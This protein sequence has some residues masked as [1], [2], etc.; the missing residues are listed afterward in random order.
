MSLNKFSKFVQQDIRDSQDPEEITSAVADN[1]LD[2]AL[3]GNVNEDVLIIKEQEGSVVS[4]GLLPLRLVN[5]RLVSA[6]TLRN[7]L[8][9]KMQQIARGKMG[10]GG[11]LENQTGR[12]VRSAMVEPQIVNVDN[13]ISLQFRYMFAPYEVFDPDA[14]IVTDGGVMKKRLATN[15]R[16]PRKL[17]AEALYEAAKEVLYRGYNIKVSQVGVNKR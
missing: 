12:L 7:L 2:L 8:T 16:N 15:A 11:R 9:V 5:G 6:L 1:F 10:K 14:D 4:K 17:F 3:T 13:N